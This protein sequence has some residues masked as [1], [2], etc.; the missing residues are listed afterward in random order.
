VLIYAIH[1]LRSSPD[2]PRGDAVET[3]VRREDAER[4]IEQVRGDKPKLASYLRIEE[5]GQ[6]VDTSSDMAVYRL[7]DTMGADLGVLEHPAPNLEPGDVVWLLDGDEAVVT[8]RV[9]AEP[10]PG[11]LVAMLEVMLSPSARPRWIPSSHA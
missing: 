1:D 7:H 11:P 6:P 8:A 2:H 5:R 3:F 10:G 9:E 4:F